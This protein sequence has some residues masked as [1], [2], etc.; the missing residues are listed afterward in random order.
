MR[1]STNR[2]HGCGFWGTWKVCEEAT[3]GVSADA[4]WATVFRVYA[5]LDEAELATWLDSSAGRHY[6]DHVLDLVAPAYGGRLSLEAGLRKADLAVWMRE[7]G[8]C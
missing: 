6:A 2:R 8:R 7:W 1:G 3:P 5:H 4:A